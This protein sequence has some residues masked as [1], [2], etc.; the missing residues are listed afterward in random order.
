LKK[1]KKG[2]AAFAVFA[3]AKV[4]QFADCR[5]KGNWRQNGMYSFIREGL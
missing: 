1:P 2:F 3:A 4:C 5:G